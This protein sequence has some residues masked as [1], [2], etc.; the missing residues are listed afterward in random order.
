VQIFTSGQ[1]AQL[2][3]QALGVSFPTA[4]LHL[5]PLEHIERARVARCGFE[6]TSQ[7]LNGLSWL[8]EMIA[9]DFGEL[10][11]GFHGIQA[12]R[13]DREYGPQMFCS[14]FPVFELPCDFSEESMRGF[15]PR[16]FF[17]NAVEPGAG[18]ISVPKSFPDQLSQKEP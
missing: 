8:S 12:A 18:P 13:R 10:T 1:E 4:E 6:K 7:V 5:C 14:C 3:K 2:E 11:L 9:E 15:V 17:E 16:L